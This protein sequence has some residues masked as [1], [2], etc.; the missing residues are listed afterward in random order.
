MLLSCEP[1]I[2]V[3]HEEM[4]RRRGGDVT[5][6]FAIEAD[7]YFIAMIGVEKTANMLYNT[8]V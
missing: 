5:G 7:H 1:P 2:E 6:Y 3:M 8:A 4:E